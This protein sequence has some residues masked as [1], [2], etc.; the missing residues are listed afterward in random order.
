MQVRPMFVNVEMTNGEGV[1]VRMLVKESVPPYIRWY[2]PTEDTNGQELLMAIIDSVEAQA[3]IRL[4]NGRPI[5]AQAVPA[6]RTYP[7]VLE[8]SLEEA[9]EY[10]T[11]AAL[12]PR[13]VMEDG[14]PRAVDAHTRPNRVNMWL[15]NNT[16]YRAEIF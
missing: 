12:V 4:S 8:M 3:F 9:V 15:N 13:V 6:N 2:F 14:K 11:T 10:I 5:S 16:V 1:I 7:H